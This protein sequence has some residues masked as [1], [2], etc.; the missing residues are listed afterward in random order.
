MFF[1]SPPFSVYWISEHSLV[2]NGGIHM[3]KLLVLLICLAL[4]TSTASAI[5]LASVD[6]V[7]YF[8]RRHSPN[9]FLADPINLEIEGTIRDITHTGPNNHYDMT[10]VID[11][12]NATAP[13]GEDLPIIDV[14]FRL[15]V[16]PIPFQVGD[17]ITV[18]GEVNPLYSSVM[19]P[20]LLA[21]YINGSDDF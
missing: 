4:F 2:I 5:T 7:Q 8:M 3:K 16:D 9:Y 19:V 11:E 1:S 18:Y 17:T 20:Y 13:V 21:R 15:H 10:L 12:P 14:H 6:Q